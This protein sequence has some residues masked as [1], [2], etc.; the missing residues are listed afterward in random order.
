MNAPIR[1]RFDDMNPSQQA[2]IL[3]NDPRF[4]K[5]AATRCGFPADQLNASAAAEYL[6][7]CCRI[8]SR[9]DLNSNQAAQH[10]FK[11]LRTEFDAWTG[12]IA[13]QR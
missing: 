11:I 2:G 5:F 4:Q 10:Q 3:C 12:K 1:Q 9:R 6:R 8:D 13:R 7:Q